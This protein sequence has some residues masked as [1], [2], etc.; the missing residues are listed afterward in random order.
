ML[1]ITGNAENLLAFRNPDGSIVVICGNTTGVAC[2]LAVNVDD[3]I[4][5]ASVDP[6]TFN[7][8]IIPAAEKG[9]SG[10]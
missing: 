8:F 9:H 7:T 6:N 5:S 1:E 3:N 10:D 2:Q 4:L